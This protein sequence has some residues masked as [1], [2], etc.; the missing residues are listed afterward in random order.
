M[1]ELWFRA[2]DRS[3]SFPWWRMAA[4]TALT[5]FRLLAA[6]HVDSVFWVFL[7]LVTVAALSMLMTRAG[8][9]HVG[10]EGVRV[11]R[12][13]GRGRLTP[14]SEVRVLW[15]Q[16]YRFA[17]TLKSV[18]MLRADGRR[19]VLPGL[20]STP[21]VPDPELPEKFARLSAW[22]ELHTDAESRLAAPPRRRYRFRRSGTWQAAAT[23]VM[24]APVAGTYAQLSDDLGKGEG[25]IGYDIGQLVPAVFLFL[26]LAFWTGALVRAWLLDRTVRF[27]WWVPL[28]ALGMLPIA[29][30]GSRVSGADARIHVSD[31]L[32]S[33]L[34]LAAGLAVAVVIGLTRDRKA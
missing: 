27:R 32:P 4:P 19:P 17:P 12:Y 3:R 10:P 31:Y 2:S 23:L 15:L 16:E 30:V 7:G 14:W 9:T 11:R 24:V 33:L 20:I 26:L 5:A 22:W 13:L 28:L 29:Q 1:D 6:R 8:W 25:W 21:S 18:R 34:T